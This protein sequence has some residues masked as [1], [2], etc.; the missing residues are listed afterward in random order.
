MFNAAIFLIEPSTVAVELA[1]NLLQHNFRDL[2]AW[3]DTA[4]YLK[5]SGLRAL[6]LV[7]WNPDKDQQDRK[8]YVSIPEVLWGIRSIHPKHHR[9][10]FPAPHARPH[11]QN[12]TDSD[13]IRQ[14]APNV[15]LVIT[16]LPEDPRLKIDGE[17]LEMVVAALVHGRWV[18]TRTKDWKSF[19]SWL[20]NK[21]IEAA[22]TARLNAVAYEL[23]KK[24]IGD[25]H[26]LAF[27]ELQKQGGWK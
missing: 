2:V 5:E 12:Q 1:R 19:A 20:D 21:H 17:I 15:Q 8:Q 14:G 9:F 27:L 6:T 26:N 22:I 10:R 7:A 16:D 13:I 25:R 23:L 11:Y 18:L 3:P 24:Y 4:A